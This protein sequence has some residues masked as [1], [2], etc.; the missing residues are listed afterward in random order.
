[1]SPRLKKVD[2]VIIV[3]MILI[4]IFVLFKIGYISESK[5]KDIPDIVFVKNGIDNTR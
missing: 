1:M 5:D 2:A 4:A 3:I